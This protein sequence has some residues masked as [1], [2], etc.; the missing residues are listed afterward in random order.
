[1]TCKYRVPDGG[2]FPRVPLSTCN[3]LRSAP[4]RACH[5]QWDLPIHCQF[6]PHAPV[7]Q[8]VLAWCKAQADVSCIFCRAF[9]LG[10]ASCESASDCVQAWYTKM[11][12]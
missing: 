10:F 5:A 4:F 9:I 3:Q 11:Q 6:R 2:A 8:P 12:V 7:K 1:M